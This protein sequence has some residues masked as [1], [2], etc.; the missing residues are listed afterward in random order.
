MNQATP[1]V[2]LLH[3]EDDFEIYNFIK[4]IKNKLGDETAQDM[5]VTWV[6]DKKLDLES[7]RAY[8]SAVPFLAPRRVVILENPSKK[9]KKKDAQEKFINLLNSIQPSTALL[10][11]ENSTLKKTNWLL[12]WSLK[13][14]GHCY[15]KNFPVKNRA[16]FARWI[17]QTVKEEGVEI[18]HEAAMLLSENVGEDSRMAK[19]EIEKLLAYVNYNRTIEAVDVAN[20]TAFGNIEGDY[21]ALINAIAANNNHLAMKELHKLL[22]EREPISLL[23]SLAGHFRLLIQ[24]REV[25]EAGGTHKTAAESLNIHPYRAQKLFE[26]ARQLSMISLEKIHQ[27]F[28]DYDFQIK[29]GRIT[30]ILALNLMVSVLT[31]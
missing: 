26:Q 16:E 29:T 12:K 8:V 25:L 31:T 30:P 20:L 18:E 19:I 10:L 28:F 13:T 24:V 1:V 22:S 9:I 2:Y 23:S 21:F 3:G 7:L 27:Q 5:N 14:S 6:D 15:V 4:N 17:I 11:I